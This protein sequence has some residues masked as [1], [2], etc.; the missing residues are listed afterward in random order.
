[1]RLLRRFPRLLGASLLGL[2]CAAAP[3]LEAAPPARAAVASESSAATKEAI[4]VLA[5]GGNAVDAAI[6]AALVAGVVSPSS[7]GLGGGGFALVWL[8]AEKRALLLDFRET[9]PQ[10]LDVAALQKGE[11]P[12]AERGKLVG[13]PGELAGLHELHRRHGRKPWAELVRPA[14]KLAR[15]GFVVEAHLAS[16]LVTKT[17]HLFQRDAS[18][19]SLLFAGGKPAK[20]GQRLRRPNLA[21]TLARIAT[22]GPA[23][24]YTG[25]IAAE[26]AKLARDN[27]GALSED[28]LRAYQVKERT[29]LTRRWEGLDVLTMPAPSS[30]G[31]IL[32]QALA[33]GSRDEFR[34]LG[35]R[36]AAYTHLLGELL[37]AGIGDR[38][39]HTG[40]PDFV[41]VDAN[42]LL[43][44]ERLA[45]RKALIALDRTHLPPA[46]VKEG[47]GTHH[48]SLLDAEGNAV[49]L[50][51]TINSAFGADLLAPASGIVLND[52]LD[53]FVSDDEARPY[54]G[55]NPNPPRPGA[56]P[57]SSMMPTL[58]LENGRVLLVAGGSGGSRIPPSVIQV[59]L[60]RLVFD[61]PIAA[62]VAARRFYPGTAL[63]TL[64]LEEGWSERDLAELTWRGEKHAQMRWSDP[65][66][67]IVENA[68]K[69][70]LAAADS[71]KHGVAATR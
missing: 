4:A 66:V 47:G 54:G 11:V 27:G 24:L 63:P 30:G 64:S 36:T 51:T 71:R 28:D 17:A 50:T 12:G 2:L 18:L 52:E 48:L 56:R 46:F 69:G 38:F 32:A 49:A 55:Q 21:K 29:P 25:P 14:E 1:M 43:A 13:T 70:A 6:S 68:S 26:L 53:D 58:V 57:A 8:A 60:A 33:W 31:L 39:R 40:D 42:A 3:A 59:L 34:R 61:E 44:P 67:Q 37:R 15:N 35:L 65:A 16:M 22:E 41:K 19:A 45:R 10:G 23:A 7:S 62:A 9:A 20:A 5:A